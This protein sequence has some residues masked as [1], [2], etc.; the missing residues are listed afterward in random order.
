MSIGYMLPKYI[1][2]KGDVGVYG[3]TRILGRCC[4]LKPQASYNLL[5][6]CMMQRPK[7]LPGLNEF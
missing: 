5:T 4:G 3:D 6:R 2:F 1:A 7:L